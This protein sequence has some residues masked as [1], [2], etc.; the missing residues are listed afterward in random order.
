MLGLI[1]HLLNNLGY[2]IVIA[3]FFTK[4]ESARNIFTR[5]KYSKKD[6]VILSLFFSGL[7]IIGT[8]VGVTYE[9]SLA[10]TRNIGVIVGGILAGPQVGIISGI[11]AGIHRLFIGVGEVSTIP[12]SIATILGGYLS[13]YL[14]KKAKG[15]HRYLYGFLG[16]F[17]VENLSMLLII[18]LNQDKALAYKIVSNIYIPMIL[19]N[20][21]GVS[22]V[23]LI[24]E[25]IVEE[26]EIIA[27]TQ[28]KLALEIAN[29]TLP[30]FR[31]R[32]SLNEVCRIIL[33]YLD[34][35]VTVLTDENQ[36][37]ASYSESEDYKVDHTEIISESAKK[38][39]ETGEILI[40]NKNTEGIDFNCISKKIKSCIIAP[41]FQGEKIK[42]ILK[43]YFDKNENITE[44]KKYL[45]IGLSQLIATQQE[46][47][48]LEN[49]RIM[50]RDAELKLLQA[51]INPHFLFNALNTTAFFVRTDV[52]KAR[53]VIID[54]S[55]YL[56]FNLE[57]FSKLVPLSLELQQVKAYINIEK[58]RFNKIESH[59]EIEEGT[60][61]IKV[62]SLIIQPLVENSI[63]HGISKNRNSGNIYIKVLK[64]ENGCR[65][66]IEDDGI[67]IKEEIIKELNSPEMGKSIG[68]KNVHTRIKLLY[69]K[70]L[71]I[72]RLEKGTRVSFDIIEEKNKG[73]NIKKGE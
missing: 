10:N 32:E 61:N 9:G 49:L 28:A 13:G 59:Y 40:A 60:E 8:Y 47:S 73:Y 34:A 20:A 14:Y 11:I 55:T 29:K 19:A 36:I 64:K 17:I 16:G 4:F 1:S 7:A 22:I 62:P 69:G 70:G 3:F 63:K 33:E 41:L 25:G 6:I 72:E 45:V 46:I 53:E 65:I 68:L 31:K 58:S 38:V 48:K 42:G 50:A 39:L 44:R 18:V 37:I 35:K 26:K 27:G 71:E 2:I 66:I 67:G 24:I 56:R 51:Q 43:I 23:I 54:L 30:Y 5:E 57:N 12:C 15:K 21:I 52:N